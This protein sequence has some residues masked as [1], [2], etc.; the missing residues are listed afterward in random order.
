[1][2]LIG[3]GLEAVALYYQYVLNQY[4]CVLCIHIRIW[5][6]AFI[7]VGAIGVIVPRGRLVLGVVS[8]LSVVSSVGMLER[9]WQTLATERRWIEGS[10]SFSSGLPSWFALDQWFPWIFGVQASCGYTPVLPFGITMAEALMVISIFA[11]LMT[12]L[13]AIALW[14]S[15]RF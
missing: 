11:L 6:L 1:M 15:R 5:V 10:C 9:S 2:S 13:V 7:V 8:I 3:L 4:P 12:S 14:R